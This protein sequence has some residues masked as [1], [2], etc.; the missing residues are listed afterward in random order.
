MRLMGEAEYRNLPPELRELIQVGMG[1]A[2]L[3]GLLDQIDLKQHI[4]DL[5]AE[6]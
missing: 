1:G 6:A 2:A 5:T 4:A 3:K